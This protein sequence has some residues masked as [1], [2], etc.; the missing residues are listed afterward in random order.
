MTNWIQAL[1]GNI[2]AVAEPAPRPDSHVS[3]L[4]PVSEALEQEGGGDAEDAE[5][6]EGDGAAEDLVV[7]PDV[8]T[9]MGD[10]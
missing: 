7:S 6:A 2:E 10:A 4:D 5:D 8:Q 9:A 1:Q 3:L